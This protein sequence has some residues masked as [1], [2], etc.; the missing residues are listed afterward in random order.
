[1]N[2]MPELAVLLQNFN[3]APCLTPYFLLLDATL[4]D[5]AST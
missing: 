2:T 3:L 1:M 4:I 5:Y